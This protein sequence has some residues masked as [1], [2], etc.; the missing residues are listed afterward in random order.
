ML[1]CHSLRI[2][3]DKSEAR[4]FGGS[5]HIT[6]FLCDSY[7]GSHHVTSFSGRY[8][9]CI[10]FLP[11]ITL[12]HI[13][14]IRY[15]IV[16]SITIAFNSSKVIGSSLVANLRH[17]VYKKTCFPLHFPSIY[18]SINFYAPKSLMDTNHLRK[19]LK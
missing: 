17:M 2:S 14:D 1:I 18:H 6:L 3:F 10:I 16:C 15:V 9:Y 4:P 13:W 12:N 5:C 7:E 8:T 19:S 11:P